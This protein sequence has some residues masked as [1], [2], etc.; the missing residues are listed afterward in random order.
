MRKVLLRPQAEADIEGIADYT[1]EQWGLKQARLYVG[2]IR[3]A[4]ERL[5]D[6]ALQHPKDDAVF[7]GLHKL[8]CGHHLVYYLVDADSVDVVRGA[9]R[10]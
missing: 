2:D 9:F 1:I 4:I 7:P 6:S 8:R 5:G 10:G 3:R